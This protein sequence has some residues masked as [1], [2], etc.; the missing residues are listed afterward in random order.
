MGIEKTQQRRIWIP[1][2]VVVGADGA[3]VRYHGVTLGVLRGRLM[4]G[5]VPRVR[6]GAI[7]RN[8]NYNNSDDDR[9]DH[10]GSETETEDAPARF[11]PITP[12]V[13]DATT[14]RP[15]AASVGR[16]RLLDAHTALASHVEIDGRYTPE[17]VVHLARAGPSPVGLIQ[18]PLEPPPYVEGDT[19]VEDENASPIPRTAT[20]L[21]GVLYSI[22]V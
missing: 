11:V 16:V 2:G 4:A 7:R 10:S 18:M 9:G 20:P 21:S 1:T 15:V 3:R 17:A 22:E 12:R 8:A 5:L 6:R 19:D 13:R 14:G